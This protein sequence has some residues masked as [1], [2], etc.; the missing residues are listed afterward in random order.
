MAVQETKDDMLR[1]PSLN[2]LSV[3]QIKGSQQLDGY[4][5]HQR[6]QLAQRIC[7]PRHEPLRILPTSDY[8]EV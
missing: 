7:V 3:G 5:D 4:A 6:L 8:F 2:Q 1:T